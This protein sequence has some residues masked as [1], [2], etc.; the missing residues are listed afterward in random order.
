M[1]IVQVNEFTWEVVNDIH[2]MHLCVVVQDFL[3]DE[4]MISSVQVRQRQYHLFNY[5]FNDMVSGLLSAGVHVRAV[6]KFI[7]LRSWL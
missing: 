5:I 4:T 7:F 3:P 2:H 6:S 1:Y